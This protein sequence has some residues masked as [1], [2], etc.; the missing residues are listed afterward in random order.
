MNHRLQPLSEGEVKTLLNDINN[1]RDQAIVRL[2]LCS[3]PSM[4]RRCILSST[5]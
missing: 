4:T 2:M 5:G 1:P 3:S